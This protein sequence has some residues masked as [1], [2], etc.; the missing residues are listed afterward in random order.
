[1]L[2][3]EARSVVNP[4][5]E[6]VPVSSEPREDW[7]FDTPRVESSLL[8]MEDVLQEIR[9]ASLPSISERVWLTIEPV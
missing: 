9:L 7:V 1:M 4:P 6:F 2:S 8:I 3:A 5:V